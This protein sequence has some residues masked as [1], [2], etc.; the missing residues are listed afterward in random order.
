MCIF[1]LNLMTIHSKVGGI[2]HIYHL[3]CVYLVDLTNIPFQSFIF[4][5]GM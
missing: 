2:I 5:L 3:E 4:L 1:L